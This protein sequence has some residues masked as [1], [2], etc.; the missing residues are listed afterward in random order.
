MWTAP[1]GTR[2]GYSPSD[3]A[4]Q[5]EITGTDWRPVKIALMG[6]P[7][8]GRTTLLK[9][10]AGS[11]DADPGKPLTVNVPDVRLDRLE[12]LHD[13]ER[14]VH[15][16]V[17]FTDIPSPAF[18]PRNIA[19]LRNAAVLCLVMDNYALGNLEEQLTGADSELML[20]DMTLLE[21]RLARLRK[22]GSGH[23]REALLLQRVYLRLESGE[24]LRTM[25]LDRGE[26]DIL[27][28]YALLSLKPLLAV[29]NRMGDP[30]TPEE[31]VREV[32][33]AHGAVV[34][35]LDAG[36][37][38]ELSAFPEDEQGEFLES[39]GYEASG[40]ERL[41]RQAQ[42][43]LDLIVFFTKGSDEVRAWP[44][45]R[46]ASAEEAAGVIH[47]DMQRGFIRAVVISFDSYMETPE[48]STL[49][50]KGELRLE[51]R[52]Y[53]VNDGDIIE[54]RFSV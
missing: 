10:L 12:E 4:P 2:S 26:Q 7:G 35:P 53:I 51:G 3:P 48:A 25:T 49:R 40:L 19:L 14:K 33:E 21:K 31:N 8:S 17:V 45:R 27:S 22:E 41:I 1:T 6:Y 39:M 5:E 42:D 46:G 34:M 52:D 29:S 37:E 13:P 20:A 9:A 23:S 24:P 47:S 28:P 43:A 15:A 54:I 38:L 36:F 16:T 18:A 44:L 32:A 50:S 11:E 30:V